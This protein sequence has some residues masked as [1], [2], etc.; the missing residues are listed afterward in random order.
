MKSSQR[1]APDSPH[2]ALDWVLLDQGTLVRKTRAGCGELNDSMPGRIT[3]ALG[4]DSGADS[5]H[6]STLPQGTSVFPQLGR[7]DPLRGQSLLRSLDPG[8]SLPRHPHFC[9]NHAFL[10]SVSLML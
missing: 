6:A 10:L 8:V 2:L 3:W 4:M 9:I 5:S 1:D 7:W